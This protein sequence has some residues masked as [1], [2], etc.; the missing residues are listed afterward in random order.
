VLLRTDRI[1]PPPIPSSASTSSLF[2]SFSQKHRINGRA[3]SPQFP[4]RLFERNRFGN[5]PLAILRSG[6]L[7]SVTKR[8]EN[9]RARQ[10][11]PER[12][13]LRNAK[14]RRG[15]ITRS[16]LDS[17]EGRSYAN[18]INV[19]PKSLSYPAKRA[20]DTHTH[21]HTDR[22]R[23]GERGRARPLSHASRVCGYPYIGYPRFGEYPPVSV[24]ATTDYR[25]ARLHG[26]AV[27]FFGEG[28]GFCVARRS[29][30]R[31]NGI[32]HR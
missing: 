13:V 3:R 29:E 7:C 15:F 21:T 19:V 1:A 27:G 31:E 26:R 2:F 17:R 28:K 14:D 11:N 6:R 23:E 4:R 9:P 20:L 30:T 32:G 8:D 25:V 24:I 22:E 18:V 16:S 12:D 5:D 10:H